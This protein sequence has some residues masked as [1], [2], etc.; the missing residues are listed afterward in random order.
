[1]ETVPRKKKDTYVQTT[2]LSEKSH[3]PYY[4]FEGPHYRFDLTPNLLFCLP[5]QGFSPPAV[6]LLFPWA[7]QGFTLLFHSFP[8]HLRLSLVS[9][10]V[11]VHMSPSQGVCLS[12][13]YKITAWP[14]P[15][16]HSQSPAFCSIVLITI[17]HTTCLA[18]LIVHWLSP[19]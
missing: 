16:Q 14:C 18:Y 9:F 13:L 3:S 10:H 1:M 17:W 2:F 12:T 4:G 15:S 6:L 8:R 7:K 5:S 19:H 11:S